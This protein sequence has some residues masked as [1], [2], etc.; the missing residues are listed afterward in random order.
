MM[1]KGEKSSYSYRAP[2]DKERKEIEAI[3]EKY[4]DTNAGSA[5]TKIKKLDKMVRRLAFYPSLIVG[6]LG[7][8]SFGLGMAFSLKWKLLHI[9]IPLTIVG[10][11]LLLLS[12]PIHIFLERALK[13]RYGPEILSLS[14]K[15]L[16]EGE[17]E[18]E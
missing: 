13:K 9:G 5:M 7:F 11:V 10:I 17:K 16:Q 15:A 2:T 12:L 3:R 6:L 14:N 4:L 1:N 8:S 18:K